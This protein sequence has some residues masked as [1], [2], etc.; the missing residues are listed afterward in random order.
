MGKDCD[1]LVAAAVVLEK[2][3]TR[4]K[5]VLLTSEAAVAAAEAAGEEGAA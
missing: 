3:I 4:L 1:P 2:G 5:D